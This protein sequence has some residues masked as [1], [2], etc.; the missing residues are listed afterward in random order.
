MIR[1]DSPSVFKLTLKLNNKLETPYKL[2]YASKQLLKVRQSDYVKPS[3]SSN[4]K[5]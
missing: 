1:N 3:V 2:K 5:M 4:M